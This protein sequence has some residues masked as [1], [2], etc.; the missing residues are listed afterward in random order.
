THA[1]PMERTRRPAATVGPR[2]LERV[3][4]ARD[5]RPVERPRPL[6]PGPVRHQAAERHL[7]RPDLPG[8]RDL[9]PDRQPVLRLP[10]LPARPEGRP[11][12][13][14]GDALRPKRPALL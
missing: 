12:R 3:L 4:R 11:Q 2:R 8:A 6:E 13:R 9:P 5:E 1:T 7:L 14:R 10:G